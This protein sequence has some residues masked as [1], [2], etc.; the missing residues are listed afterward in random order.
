MVLS[1]TR[2]RYAPAGKWGES[3]QRVNVMLTPTAT[4]RIDEIAEALQLTRSEVLE[5]LCRTEC[6][7]VEALKGIGDEG[8]EP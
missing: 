3:K 1:M 8:V 6:L 5:R 7:S 2:E 4:S